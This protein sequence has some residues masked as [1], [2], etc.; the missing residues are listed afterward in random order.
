[1]SDESDPAMQT[2]MEAARNSHSGQKLTES[3]FDKAWSLSGVVEREIRRSGSFREALTDYAHA[4]AR[5]EKIDAMQGEAALRD[6][7]KGRYGRTMNAMREDLLDREVE[8]KQGGDD[9][10]LRHARQVGARISEGETMPFYRAYD[11][12][13]NRMAQDQRITE[14]GAKIMMKEAYARAEGRD[15]YDDGKA[16][17][18]RHHRPV[19]EAERR[20]RT[21]EN[22]GDIT[23]R[24]MRSYMPG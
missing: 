22:V 7:F 11:I 18:E 17:E 19:R 14:S 6:V 2:P 1:M 3:Q 20:E 24:R 23:G 13:A 5:T 8:L 16:L 15:L 12:E 10:A 9:H 4:F 21:Q